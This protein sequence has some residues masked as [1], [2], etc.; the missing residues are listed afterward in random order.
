M[1]KRVTLQIIAAI[2]VL[3]SGLAGMIIYLART[4]IITIEMAILMLIGLLGIYIGFGILIFAYRL[5]RKL[6]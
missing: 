3:F 6:E 2:I 5:V 4:R 1:H